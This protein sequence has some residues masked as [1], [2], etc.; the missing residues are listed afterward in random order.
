MSTIT[1]AAP[2][3]DREWILPYYL[4]HIENIDYPK[5]K[6]E[7]LF[8]INDSSDNTYHLL[9]DFKN[10]HINSYK[11]IRLDTYNR[12]MPSDIRE[13][14]SRKKYIFDHLSKLKNYIMSKVKTDFLLFLDSDILV[15]SDIITNL[16]NHQKDIV[17]GLIWNGYLVS[18]EKPYL[19]PN[20]MK[21]IENNQ[22]S[23]I[24]NYR[25]KNIDP[26]PHLINV[27][28]TGA[29]ILLSKKVYKSIKYGF[30]PQGED[31]YFCKMAQN[32]GFDIY[33]DLGVFCHHIMNEKLLR[34]YINEEKSV[35]VSPHS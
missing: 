32:H 10:T 9:N 19:Y 5:D 3:R 15:P 25:I 16:L 28:L 12:N 26:S 30:H 27:D 1:I 18:P 34:E 2:I 6:I 7:L 20:V 31:A 35:T 29:V 4:K 17:S 22:Y 14:V 8:V 21:L 24:V 33:C 11:K 23:H 13:I